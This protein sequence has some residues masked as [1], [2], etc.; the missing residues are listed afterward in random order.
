MKGLETLFSRYF[1]SVVL[2][3]AESRLL[4]RA[5]QGRKL[6]GRRGEVMSTIW[7]LF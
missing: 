6:R 2:E 4:K 7:R 1:L 3:G 5:V